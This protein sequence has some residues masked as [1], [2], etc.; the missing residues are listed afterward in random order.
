MEDV[1][2]WLLRPLE[3]HLGKIMVDIFKLSE[4]VMSMDEETWAR[5]ANPWSVYTRFTCLPLVALAIWSRVWLGWWSLIPLAAALFW[6]WY[7]PRAFPPVS[8]NDGWAY[9][10][11]EGER[12]F[13]ERRRIQIP[14]HHL[15][16]ARRLTLFSAVGG[17]ILVYGLM[18]LNVWA[19]LCGLSLTITAKTWFVDRMV[20]LFEDNRRRAS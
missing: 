19:A 12:L 20:W 18:T 6:I 4:R 3:R 16:M 17:A 2:V 10:G 9:M 14:M 8:S 13:L 15:V 1:V 11:V 7:N 5:H